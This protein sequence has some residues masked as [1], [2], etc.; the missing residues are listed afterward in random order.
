MSKRYGIVYS[1]VCGEI[2]LTDEPTATEAMKAIIHLLRLCA[3]PH[4]FHTPGLTS[5]VSRILPE[6]FNRIQLRR[7]VL[8]QSEVGQWGAEVKEQGKQLPS[9]EGTGQWLT[10][11][12]NDGIGHYI[13]SPNP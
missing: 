1:T 6:R 12:H 3:K 9:E 8:C 2:M 5:N 4:N 11:L 13:S 7:I 10:W